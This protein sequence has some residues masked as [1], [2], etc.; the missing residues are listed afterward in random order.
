MKDVKLRKYI[1]PTVKEKKLK[2]NFFLTNSVFLDQ[3]N[4]LGKVYASSIGESESGPSDCC[5]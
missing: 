4:I 1:K 5:E 2:L 3:F